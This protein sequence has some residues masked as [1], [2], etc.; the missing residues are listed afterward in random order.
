MA[1]TMI[2]I[3]KDKEFKEFLLAQKEPRHREIMVGVDK[4]LKLHPETK[5]AKSFAG[6]MIQKE[7]YDSNRNCSIYFQFQ[8]MQRN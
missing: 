2:Q 6:K 8:L 4:T 3:D 7:R 5:K 1:L